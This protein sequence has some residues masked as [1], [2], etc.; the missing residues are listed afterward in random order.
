MSQTSI[1]IDAEKRE[2]LRKGTTNRLRAE[3]KLPAILCRKGK[4]SVSISVDGKALN[5]AYFRGGIFSQVVE[6]NLGGEKVTALPKVVQIHPVTDMPLHI[7]FTQVEEN[8]NVTVPVP[9]VFLN[10]EKSP[11]IKRGAVLNIVRRTIDIKCKANNI[12]A[13]FEI[14]LTGR[15]IG[16]SIHVRHLNLPEYWQP[17]ITDRDFT[18]ATIMGKGGK[19]DAADEEEEGAAAAAPAAKGAA[20]KK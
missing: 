10:H 7:D 13:K 4:D 6:L 16:Q 15:H 14:D 12:P 20:A 19:A 2:D 17:A 8:D 1:R 11:G 3:G 9:V 5:A 18:I